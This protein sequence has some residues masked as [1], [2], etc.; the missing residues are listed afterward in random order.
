MN[1]A[2]ERAAPVFVVGFAVRLVAAGVTTVSDINPASRY[3]A[4]SFAE[5][6]EAIARGVREGRPYAYYP[7]SENLSHLL[8]PFPPGDPN[9]L[10]GTLL[11]PFWLLPGPSAFYARLANAFIGAFAI[12]NVYLIA[13]HYHSHQAG[14]V[15]TLPMIF[16][17]SIV[18]V[19]S[20][21]LREALVLF[22]FTTAA[23]LLILPSQRRSKLA[24]YVLALVV[25]DVALLLR[26]V[27]TFVVTAAIAVSLG[28][29]VIE[30]RHLSRMA[31]GIGAALS[32][33]AVL[34]SL[35]FLRRT[36]E[37]LAETRVER[38][39]GRAVYL[40]HAVPRAPL[41]LLAFSWI[42]AAYFLYAPFP[43][44]VQTVPDFI[45]SV[46][47]LFTMGFTLAAMWGVRSLGRTD[48]T[49]T[50]GLLVGLVAGLVLYG[51]GTVNYGTGMRHR[52][53]F[54]W[55]VF[56]FGGI[57]VGD[58]VK[59]HWPSRQWNSSSGRST[60][61]PKRRPDSDEDRP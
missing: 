6:A 48:A 50:A 28:V 21:L 58:Q 53:M 3:D 32:P 61:G 51:V 57:G 56:L 42:G 9:L 31:I 20:T 23:R 36:I 4:A 14:V 59:L 24:S 38:A 45:V 11:A 34:L 43:W 44:M 55:V 8:V 26:E 54:L 2:S 47:G 18:A 37:F 39:S 29:Y 41:E 7:G 15:A 49:V 40:P 27:N 5:T 17:P 12:Y 13:R 60:R 35:P 1:T 46:E 10:W 25:L 33:I 52:Q 22:G 30:S 16:Y 19:H